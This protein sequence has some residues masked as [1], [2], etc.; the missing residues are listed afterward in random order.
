MKHIF[1]FFLVFVITPLMSQ[2][3]SAPELTS[4]E[5]SPQ[6]VDITNGP[7]EVTVTVGATDDVSGVKNMF[8]LYILPNG[9]P[10]GTSSSLISGTNLDGVWEASYTI[11]QYTQTGTG[12]ISSITLNDNVGNQLILLYQDLIDLGY[13]PDFEI[14][15]NNPPDLIPPELTSFSVS[16]Q[17]V[18]ITNGPIEVTV[19]VGATDDLSGVK[20]MFPLYILP[21][22]NPIGTSSSLI[23]GTNLDGV[24][25]ASYI[26]PQYTQTGTGT[27]S[28]ITL[29]DNVGNQLILLYQDLIDL[30]YDP[31][32]EIIDNNP[33]DLIPPELTSFSVSPQIVDI[34]NGPIEVTVTVGATDDLSGVKNMFPLYILPNGN[35]I[36]TSSS[37]I[38]GTNLDGVWEASYII[39]Q[40]T[41]TGTRTISSITLND[42]VG[43]QLI[44]LYQDLIDLGYDPDF[45]IIDNNALPVEYY[46]ALRIENNNELTWATSQQVNNAHFEIE[47]SKDG[48][49]FKEIARIKGEG[50][51][52]LINHYKYVHLNQII[53]NNYYR[54]KQVDNDGKFSYSNVVFAEYLANKFSVYPNPV[55]NRLMVNSPM[56]DIL[57]IFNELGQ[58]VGN[59]KIYKGK[60]EVD[61]SG[62][63]S[64][65]YLLI[66]SNGTVERVVR[67]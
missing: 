15:D 17:I 44:L 41:Q 14:I 6:I 59:Y 31:D 49:L 64:G 53:G 55:S 39:P 18:D 1:S 11:P 22:G 58:K 61:M 66:F 33:P 50:N 28:S 3:N 63:G 65:L 56:H 60:T 46:Q 62:F 36:G 2:D 25:E 21:N 26:I 30:G 29:N 8:P 16:P 12:T 40:Y 67:N 32:F 43:N 5:V 48:R 35:P 38:S 7:I 4:F 13:D 54:I 9:N 23:S 37:L 52:T 19:T 47:H 45:E 57:N 34:T 27:I 20:N 51:T 10:I 42:N 24:W